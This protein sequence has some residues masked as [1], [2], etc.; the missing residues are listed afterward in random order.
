MEYDEHDG[1]RNGMHE[2][3]EVSQA[4][5]CH[6]FHGWFQKADGSRRVRR[7]HGAVMRMSNWR[8]PRTTARRS[9]LNLEDKGWQSQV[10]TR[11]QEKKDGQITR[12]RCFLVRST[13]RTRPRASSLLR[14]IVGWILDGRLDPARRRWSVRWAARFV[15]GEGFEKH[16]HPSSPPP[17]P[18]K[19]EPHVCA[20][21]SI[22]TA[23]WIPQPALLLL[24][25]SIPFH[26]PSI[27][28]PSV[29]LPPISGPRP[30]SSSSAFVRR[31]SLPITLLHPTPPHS[32]TS[33]PRRRS[34]PANLAATLAPI[35][36]FA[37]ERFSPL[38]A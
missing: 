2:Y 28:H 32:T 34:T 36:L 31:H 21:S 35:D 4:F 3:V 13:A 10:S 25:N 7:L 33:H 30:A 37:K 8:R 5:S 23:S 24:H 1:H 19:K 16:S 20:V 9:E 38:C 27:S 26:Y 12:Q 11:A 17:L 6:S 18:P 14:P 29:L 15:L 22:P